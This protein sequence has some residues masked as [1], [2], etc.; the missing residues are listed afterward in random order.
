MRHF[1]LPPDRVFVVGE[2][3]DPVFRVIEQPRL[4][5][6]LRSLGIDERHRLVVYVGGFGPHKNLEGLVEAFNSISGQGEFSDVRLVMVGE[7]KKEIF[8]SYY[9]RIAALV[10]QLGLADR[11]CFTGYLPDEDLVALLN[12]STV[13]VLPSLMEGFGLPAI[14]AAACGCP[15]IATKESPLPELLGSGGLYFA[16][17]QQK[18]LKSA[19][20]KV[21]GSE[22]LRR[23]MREAGLAAASRL[24]WDAAARQ[25]MN[26]ITQ[27]A[28]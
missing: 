1:G 14:E 28:A 19:M 22:P 3:S 25:M 16:P 27:V 5:P 23:S 10:G 4:S 13:L 11:T 17:S 8:H 21:L 26:V 24:T 9:E 6:P 18:E 12:L 20:E 15:V 7:F 2:A